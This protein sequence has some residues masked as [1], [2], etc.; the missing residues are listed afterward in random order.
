M[1]ERTVKHRIKNMANNMP[2]LTERL[3]KD[4]TDNKNL[5]IFLKQNAKKFHNYLYYRQKKIYEI[6]RTTRK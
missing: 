5:Q 2:F 1:T 4:K 6:R 3:V